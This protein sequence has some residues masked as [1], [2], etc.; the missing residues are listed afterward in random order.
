MHHSILKKHQIHSSNEIVVAC[1]GFGQQLV[2]LLPV[3]DR[4]VLWFADAAGEVTV[5]VGFLKY[6]A[7]VYFLDSR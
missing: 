6:D 7:F 1:H 2:E 5:D 4:H 3:L